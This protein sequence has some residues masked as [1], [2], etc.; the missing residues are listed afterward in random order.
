M[1]ILFYL[2]RALAG[3]RFDVGGFLETAQQVHTID[4]QADQAKNQTGKTTSL[5]ECFCNLAKYVFGIISIQGKHAEAIE[6][7][8]RRPYQREAQDFARI[9][10]F[11]SLLARSSK[12]NG[13][14]VPVFAGGNLCFC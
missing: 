6:N 9:H 12:R 3:L 8:G 13:P 2:R 1:R 10:Y 4:K 14:F 11:T 7:S 5:E